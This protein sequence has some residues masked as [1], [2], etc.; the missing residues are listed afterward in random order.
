MSLL[1]LT[2]KPFSEDA[3]YAADRFWFVLDGASGLGPSLLH[4]TM[5]DAAL[6]VRMLKDALIERLENPDY[7]VCPLEELL[8]DAVQSISGPFLDAAG[9]KEDDFSL[10]SCTICLLRKR[11]DAEKEWLDT[12]ILGDSPLYL[13]KTDGTV[14]RLADPAVSVLDDAVI[15]RMQQIAAEQN[16][17]FLAARQQPEIKALL[18]ANRALKNTPSGYAICSP[19]NAWKGRSLQKTFDAD[20]IQA[21][22]LMSDGFEQ[23]A[24]LAG[25]DASAFLDAVLKNPQSCMEQ[26]Y[27]L[28]E[29]D[30]E[31]IKLPR[32]KKRDDTTVLTVS[33]H[34]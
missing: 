17:P 25:L 10:P 7:E 5:S 12:L 28:Q 32:L 18:Q 24:D 34:K 26:L 1:E 3:A 4:Q 23:Y 33:L 8:L 29:M 2:E 15:A 16:I 31:C 19:G 20:R 9:G 6:F 30:A 13:K 22:A 27:R 21:A 14:L 11:Q